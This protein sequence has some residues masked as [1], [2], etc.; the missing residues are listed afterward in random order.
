MVQKKH[1]LWGLLSLLALTVAC[2]SPT[3]LGSAHVPSTSPLSPSLSGQSAHEPLP[4][5][6]PALLPTRLF[7]TLPPG[8]DVQTQTYR[9]TFLQKYGVNPFVEAQTDP[10]STFAADVDTAAYSLARSYIRQGSLPPIATVRTEEFINAMPYT[11]PQ[12]VTDKFAI[13]TEIATPDFGSDKG[14]LRIGIQGRDILAPQRKSAM[15]TFV[16]D[17]SG[18]M[19]TENRLGAVKQSLRLLVEQLQPQDQ[20]AIVIYGHQARVVLAPTAGDN[21]SQ[22]LAVI[23][24]LRPEGATNVEAGLLLGYQMATQQFKPE[25]INRVIL[26]SD[27][28][29]NVGNTGP[30]AILARIRQQAEKGVSLTTIGFGMGDYNDT[31]MEQLANQGDGLY[32]YV[33]TVDEARRIFV[34]NLTRTLQ[35]LAKDMKIQVRFDPAQVAQYRLLGYENRALADQDFRNDR[36][37]A[38]EVGA[39]HSVTAVYAVRFHAA[40][41]AGPIADITLRYKDI[42]NHEQMVE[43]SHR[44]S[45]QELLRFAQASSDFRLAVAVAEYAE[46]LRQSPFAVMSPLERVATEVND[47]RRTRP[48]D[49]YLAELADLIQRTQRLRQPSSQTVQTLLAQAENTSQYPLWRDYL[50]QQLVGRGGVAE[51]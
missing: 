41:A 16:I 26:C 35:L 24:R 5:A 9:Q 4:L 43:Q 2:S 7:P 10:L 49:A 20:V 6:D 47:L 18:S 3:Y 12:P 40:V 21:K 28:V 42:D 29:A 27:G 31:L 13:Y 36:V 25:A 48:Q 34:E 44:V 1:G 37:D 32:A 39:N 11:Y 8:A 19:N 23:D 17:V 51:E 50:L 30:E 45:G 15:L 22:I 33:D 46:I 38:G 14:Y